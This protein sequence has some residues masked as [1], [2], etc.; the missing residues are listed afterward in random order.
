MTYE[1]GGI[2]M[3]LRGFFTAFPQT[4]DSHITEQVTTHL[5]AEDPPLGRGTD[6]ASLNIQR[7]RDHGLP[8]YTAWRQ[9]C[10]LWVPSSFDDLEDIMTKEYVERFRQLYR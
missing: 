10:G 9:W 1:A 3:V 7:G 5:F 2:D 6:L 4:V 8:G